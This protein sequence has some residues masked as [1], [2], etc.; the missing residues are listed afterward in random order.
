VTV[1]SEAEY[2]KVLGE[3]RSALVRFKPGQKV[4]DEIVA[5]RDQ[6]F[7]KYRP[8]FSPEHVPSLTKEEFTS[9]LYFENNRHWSGLY[10]QGLGAAGD[11]ERLRGSLA[12]LLNERRP[13]RERFPE[14]LSMV[15]GFGKAIATGILTV[16]Y[17]EKYGVWNNTSEAGLRQVGLWPNFERGEGVGGRYEQINS[18]I[19]RLSSDLG[20]DLWTLDA[21]WWFLLEPERLPQARAEATPDTVRGGESFA[22]ERQLEDFLL[23]NWDRTPLAKE[24]TIFRTS[25]DP[26]AG[27]QFPTDVGRVDILAVHREQPRFLV[28]ELKRNQSTDQTVGQALR[29]VGWVKKHLAKDGQSVE[30]LIIA[31]KA[32]KDAQYALSTLPNVSMMTYEVEFRL[33]KLEPLPG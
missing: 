5:T 3:L 31:H 24:W 26:E 4:Y 13:I 8:I 6:V 15:S 7:A 22:L 32:E 11:I 19:V 33:R 14:A 10:R 9:F 2:S 27:N 17:P 16:A 21:L 30:A 28:V 1:A 23:E 18:L 29:Y 20:I 25:D 12:I